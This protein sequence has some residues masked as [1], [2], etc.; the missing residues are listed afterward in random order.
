MG[1][2]KSRLL[3]SFIFPTLFPTYSVKFNTFQE[4]SV[5]HLFYNYMKYQNNLSSS[6][7][8]QFILSAFHAVNGGSNPPED[9]RYFKDLG[10]NLSPFFVVGQICPT[11]CPTKKIQINS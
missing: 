5:Q 8:M 1:K 11:L 4:I 10:K 2:T 3:L 6:I 7:C 9:A